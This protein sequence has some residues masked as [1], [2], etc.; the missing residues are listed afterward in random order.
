VSARRR[1]CSAHTA[2][3]R[4]ELM[5]DVAMLLIAAACFAVIVGI[6]YALDRI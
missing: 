4:V 5:D 1:G 6:L 2:G 3:R